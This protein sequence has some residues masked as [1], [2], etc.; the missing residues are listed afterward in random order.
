MLAGLPA[1]QVRALYP[2]RASFASRWETT[3]ITTPGQLRAELSRTRERGWA[4]EEGDV[5]P[6]FA[7]VAVAAHDHRGLP[8]AGVALT[9]LGHK[10]D[11]ERRA[12]LVGHV[13]RTAEVLT[14]R[15][16]GAVPGGGD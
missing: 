11:D 16:H 15:L 10:I 14:R 8:V 9:F 5:T 3:A 13:R 2:D 7:S 1:A 12:E 6:N 4:V